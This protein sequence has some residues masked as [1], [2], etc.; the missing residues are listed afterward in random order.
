MEITIRKA[1]VND[2]E[3]VHH[4]VNELAIFENEPEAV[5][6]DVQYYKNCFEEGIF[7]ALV[8]EVG[9]KI[10]GV[11][12]YYMTFSTWKG[13]MIYLEDFVVNSDFRN[14]GV[15]Q[16]LWNALVQESKTQKSKLLKWQ[17]LDWN[18]DAIRFYEKNGATIETE[19]WNGK[20]I[21]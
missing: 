3:R 11:T 19:W 13:K 20:I 1:N 4:L 9:S 14:M 17:V 12:I 2:M 10:I 8:A 15:G 6:I 7:Q 16:K 5:K 21:F 18:K